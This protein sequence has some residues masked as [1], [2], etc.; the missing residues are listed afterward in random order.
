MDDIDRIGK[1]INEQKGTIT[2]VLSLLTSIVRALPIDQQAKAL[3]AFDTE[4]EV[5]RTVLLNSQAPD[6]VLN[7]FDLLVKALDSIRPDR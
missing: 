1:A 5:A 2:A 3:A 6:D 7:G 4:C